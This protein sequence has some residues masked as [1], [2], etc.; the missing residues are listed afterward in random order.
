MSTYEDALGDLL[1]GSHL[2]SVRELAGLVRDAGR[3]MGFRET[4]M[5]VID[6]QQIR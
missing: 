5:Y 6:L 3:R 2:R 1:A 4:A